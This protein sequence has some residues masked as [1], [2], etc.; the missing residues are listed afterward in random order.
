MLLPRRNHHWLALC[1]FLALTLAVGV[2][3]GFAT[4][5]GVEGWYAKLAKPSF[6]PPDWLFAPVWTFLYVLMAIAAWRVWRTRGLISPPLVLFLVQLAL[7]FAWPFIFFSAHKTGLALAE[8]VVLL[9]MIVLT[10][11]SFL[12]VDR[13]ASAL[14][15]PYVAWTSFATLLTVEIYHLN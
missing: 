10:G 2:S 3:A 11:M 12:R 7:N 4:A 14:M 13:L 5:N 6:N 1:G 15:L 9:V 8:I